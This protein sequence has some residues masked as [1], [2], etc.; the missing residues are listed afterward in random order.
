MSK[1][2]H[3]FALLCFLG[4]VAAYFAGLVIPAIAIS[5]LGFAL[6]VTAWVVW[7]N[8]G[9]PAGPESNKQSEP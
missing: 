2:A 7:L 9:D 5:A 8:S 6:E 3:R 1:K 4:A